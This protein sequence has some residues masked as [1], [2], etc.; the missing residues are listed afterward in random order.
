[1]NAITAGE[2][3]IGRLTYEGNPNPPASCLLH[4]TDV[5]IYAD[6]P[7][8]SEN[9]PYKGWFPLASSKADQR[10]VP[11]L[12]FFEDNSGHVALIACHDIRSDRNILNG[13]GLGRLKPRFAVIG[14]QPGTDFT[15]FHSLASDIDGLVQWTGA[16]HVHTTTR[17]DGTTSY[18][19]AAPEDIP[20]AG[21]DGL[22]LQPTVTTSR[23]P[24][25][26][27]SVGSMRVVTKY[28]EPSTWSTH[29][30][31]HHAI[32]DLVSVALWQPAGFRAHYASRTDHPLQ[33]VNGELFHGTYWLQVETTATEIGVHPPVE[34]RPAQFCYGD[35]GAVG[36]AE[37]ITL[38]RTW[39]KAIRPLSTLTRTKGSFLEM[40]FAQLGIG[41]EALGYH[42]AKELGIANFPEG[43]I[44]R[45]KGGK[46]KELRSVWLE[47]LLRL[48]PATSP[49]ARAA[50]DDQWATATADAF[51]DVKHADRPA[52]DIPNVYQ[53]LADGIEAFRCWTHDRLTDH[54]T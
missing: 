8:T 34:D 50:V 31:V 23:R 36:V 35:I 32:R 20:I 30:E 1:M 15:A 53:L 6:L 5:G 11:E 45:P 44:D 49:R 22:T 29:L 38:H 2:P 51:K 17:E 21:V 7:W 33:S 42:L 14:A 46:P 47:E 43:I 16:Q 4:R 48:I 24:H 18:T 37:W 40:Q 26:F 28:A 27:T 9:D 3:R 41:L 10:T 19:F 52:A 12:L 25:T 54:T 39:S 13:Q